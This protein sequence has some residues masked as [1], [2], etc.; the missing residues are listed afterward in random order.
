MSNMAGF[1]GYN[2]QP[3]TQ[4]FSPK[5]GSSPTPPRHQ[6]KLVW[7]LARER[8]DVESNV[9][10]KTDIDK[11]GVQAFQRIMFDVCPSLKIGEQPQ[12]PTQNFYG[13]ELHGVICMGNGE[14]FPSLGMTTTTETGI[15]ETLLHC[16]DL[17]A[18]PHRS[19]TCAPA[20]LPL[21]TTPAPPLCPTS[22]SAP[23]L[24]RR[25]ACP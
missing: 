19:S 23:P 14:T 20:P 16:G 15:G 25:P 22:I 21:T 5:L 10:V 18:Y 7:R 8:S 11:M 2:A 9:S 4:H 13:D 12:C 3:L 17:R 1:H 24:D 6:A